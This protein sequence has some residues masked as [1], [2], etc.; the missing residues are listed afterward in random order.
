MKD[1]YNSSFHNEIAPICIRSDY[2]NYNYCAASINMAASTQTLKTIEKIWN[3]IYPEA[4]Y[5]YGF[6]D[7][8]VAQFY[9]LDDL[10]LKLIEFFAGVAILI[11]CLGLYG[12]VSFLAIQK[13]KEIAVRKV[14][15]A[16]I[17]K[18]LWLFGKEFFVLVLIAFLVASPIAWWAMN[19]YLQ[20]FKY[21]IALGAGIFIISI[22]STTLI[23]LS[24]I[25]FQSLKAAIASPAKSLRSE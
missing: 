13:R 6:E 12:L 15:G 25:G 5:S 21:R 18:I 8:L 17:E 24:T 4:V 16:G 3:D 20:D 14:L 23:A 19:D 2:K 9:S 10:I 22:S 1:F 7:D 11:G